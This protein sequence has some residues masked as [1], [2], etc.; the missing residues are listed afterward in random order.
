[1]RYQKF[2]ALAA[3]AALTAVL[4]GCVSVPSGDQGQQDPGGSQS[5]TQQQTQG[6][7]QGGAADNPF[8]GSDQTT[9]QP[10][11]SQQVQTVDLTVNVNGQEQTVTAAVYTG[12]G[13][14][15]AVPEGWEQDHNEP[16]WNPYH[17]DDVELTV[18]YYTGM[19]AADILPLFQRDEDDYVFEAAQESS[20]AG[21]QNVTELRGSEMDDDRVQEMVAYFI[22]VSTDR[23][24]ACYGIILECPADLAQSYGGYLGAMANSFTL[25]NAAG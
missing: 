7:T 5:D 1:M 24:K 2:A 6:Q 16:Q 12:S 4:A 10:Q 15:I 3:A 18:R 9:Q 14:T 19:S 17:V 11:D 21:L 8:A 20:L 25:T 23:T 22:D 13:Y